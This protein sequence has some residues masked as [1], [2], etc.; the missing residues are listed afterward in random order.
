MECVK[1]I[2]GPVGTRTGA[3]LALGAAGSVSQ[4]YTTTLLCGVVG[5]LSRC[6]IPIF[7]LNGC[8]SF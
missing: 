2:T 4:Y 6:Y 7:A 5:S 1:G 3:T 8:I